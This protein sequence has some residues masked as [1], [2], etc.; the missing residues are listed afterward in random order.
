MH[1]VLVVKLFLD[2]CIHA[3][4]NSGLRIHRT[5]KMHKLSAPFKI[6]FGDI[7]IKKNNLKM[8]MYLVLQSIRTQCV[9]LILFAMKDVL[10]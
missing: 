3:I 10:N 7:F 4:L 9:S 1:Y 5:T 2:N 6:F 8:Y